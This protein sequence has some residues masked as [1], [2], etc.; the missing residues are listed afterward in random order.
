[1]PFDSELYQST[2]LYERVK[3]VKSTDAI[4]VVYQQDRSRSSRNAGA[5]LPADKRKRAK[6]ILDELEK[7]GVAFQKNINED[8][9]TVTITPAE[10]AGMSEAWIAARKRDDQGNLVLGMD[11]PTDPAV[12]RTG[13]R[14][15]CPAAGLAGEEPRGRP[16]EPEDPRAGAAAAL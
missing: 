8:G 10:A 16:E 12:P 7:L 1:M 2:A 15:R 6:E 5:T 9:T 13:D 11:Y 4:D 3:A 14:R